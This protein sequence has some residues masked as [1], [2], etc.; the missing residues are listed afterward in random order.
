MIVLLTVADLKELINELLRDCL[1]ESINN[2]R[3]PSVNHE[4]RTY[5]YS[6]AELANC[7]GFGKTKV[8]QMKSNGTFDGCYISHGRKSIYDVTAILEKLRNGDV[9]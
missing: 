3:E 1:P 5:A 8:Q 9:N 2:H 7:L 6:I 4:N